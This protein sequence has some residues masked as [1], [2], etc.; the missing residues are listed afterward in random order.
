M[1]LCQEHHVHWSVLRASIPLPEVLQVL[2]CKGCVQ[3]AL[4]VP[5]CQNKRNSWRPCIGQWSSG[6]ICKRDTHLLLHAD[7][8]QHAME[9]FKRL[10]SDAISLLGTRTYFKPKRY[11]ITYIHMSVCIEFSQRTY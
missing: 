7:S 4:L 6:R 9:A 8:E 3:Q 1:I 5:I 10:C 2:S 11:R